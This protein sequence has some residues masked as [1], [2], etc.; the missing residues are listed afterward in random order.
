[1]T[2]IRRAASI[3]CF[4]VS[5]AILAG[6]ATACNDPL[7]PLPPHDDEHRDPNP[8]ETAFQW[9]PSAPGMYVVAV[10]ATPV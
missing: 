7:D 6:T 9:I 8:D 2:T 3:A 4:S 5:I 10:T 1:M